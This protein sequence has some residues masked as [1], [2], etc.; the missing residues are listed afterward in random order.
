MSTKDSFSD[1]DEKQVQVNVHVAVA[2]QDVDTA[3]RLAAGV[4]Q[5][6]TPEESNRLRKK[7]DW[8][9]LP[10]MCSEYPDGRGFSTSALTCVRLSSSLL[11]PVH[12]QDD[13]GELGYSW[14]QVRTWAAGVGLGLTF[15]FCREATHL[16]TNQ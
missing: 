16:T 9:I 12:G 3:A 8:H 1:A 5:E 13:S 7:I 14:D 2:D 4:D 10:L 6:L 11:D 15:A